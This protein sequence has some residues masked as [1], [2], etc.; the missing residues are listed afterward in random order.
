MQNIPYARKPASWSSPLSDLAVGTCQRSRISF[1]AK[2][3]PCEVIEASGQI[4]G[5][6]LAR[7]WTRLGPPTFRSLY[8]SGLS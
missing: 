5:V 2:W 1:K 6:S 3:E 8:Y 4:V 7:R